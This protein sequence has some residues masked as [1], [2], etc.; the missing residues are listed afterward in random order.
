MDGGAWIAALGGLGFGIISASQQSA[1]EKAALRHQKET[2][3][4]QYEY[5]KEYSDRQ[6]ELQN[7]EARESLDTAER[8]LNEQVGQS[9][10]RFNL[11]LLSQAYGIQNAQ[12]QAA[13]NVGA[14]LAAEGMSGTR[15]NG[16]GGLMRDYER[17]NLERNVE[18]QRRDNNLSLLGMLSQA[19]NAAAD[20]E[21]ERASWNLGGYRY[22]Q[23]RAQNEYNRQI[24][25]LGQEEFDWQISQ[26]GA[27]GLDYF[28]SA[29][30]GAK[31]GIDLYNSLK[32]SAQFTGTPQQ[33]V[34]GNIQGNAQGYVDFNVG[35]AGSGLARGWDNFF[36]GMA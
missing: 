14:S 35:P 31:T 6:F 36:G 20:I 24:A 27:T 16:A 28:T 19:G 22:E 33:N 26:A 9:V 12:I 13:S 15:G 18:L 5:G 8:R 11:G 25:K 1:R 32:G 30:Q 21:R 4:K 3:W 17:I 34:Q 2:A 10:D 7:R 23:N 29:L